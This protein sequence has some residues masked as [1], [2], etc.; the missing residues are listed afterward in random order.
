MRLVK[1]RL[2]D[3][4][5]WF[6]GNSI[7]LNQEHKVSEFINADSLSA[8]DIAII[9]KSIAI[10]QIRAY[11]PESRRLKN[12]EDAGFIAGEFAVNIEDIEDDESDTIPEV[13]SMTISNEEDD[14]DEEDEEDEGPTEVD[15][16]NAALLLNKNGNTV[17][18][19]IRSIPRTDEGLLL[20]HA[21]L[22]TEESGK[23]R[24]GIINII[25]Q[26]IMEF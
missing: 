12:I 21:C 19:T 14:E 15:F 23:N 24:A 6:L 11:D 9:N 26:S 2:A 3:S 8:E 7:K 13:F 22:E 17:R 25:K 4:P 20:L 10:G 5:F 18:K 1:F 16:D